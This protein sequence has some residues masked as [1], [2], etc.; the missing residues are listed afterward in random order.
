MTRAA[1][2]VILRIS[3]ICLAWRT[4]KAL[5]RNSRQQNKQSTIS[6]THHHIEIDWE[7]LQL[8]ALYAFHVIY[9]YSSLEWIVSFLPLYHYFKMIFLIVTFLIPNT[10]FANFWFEL[11]LVPMMQRIHDLLN[12]DWRDFI[13]AEAVL[14]PWQILDLFILPG[15]ISDEEAK[16]MMKL[17]QRQLEKALNS[18]YSFSVVETQEHREEDAVDSSK[19]YVDSGV[20][21]D[22]DGDS[23]VDNNDGNS[24]NER[25]L[26]TA[27]T[28][29]SACVSPSDKSIT[30]PKSPRRTRL[31]HSIEPSLQSSSL[32]SPIARSR[33][34]ASSLHLR[35]FSQDYHISKTSSRPTPESLHRRPKSNAAVSSPFMP[36][37]DSTGCKTR[38][39]LAK[40]Q[41]IRSSL[42]PRKK[43]ILH[44]PPSVAFKQTKASLL[45]QTSKSPLKHSNR[46]NPETGFQRDKNSLH[47]DDD[48]TIS[49]SSRRS[50]GNSMRKF[51]TG[52]DNIRIRDFLFD[53]ELPS[54]PS[55]KRINDADDMSVR[56]VKS[57]FYQHSRPRRSVR[58]RI[59]EEKR[60]SLEEWRKERDSLKT[61][62]GQ[63]ERSSS[64]NTSSS[65]Q[66]RTSARNTAASISS[67]KS[68]E[69]FAGQN[70]ERKTGLSHSHPSVQQ[71]MSRRSARLATKKEISE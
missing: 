36:N 64:R 39:P 46:P 2:D 9:V 8:W 60:K 20:D 23:D 53:L 22:F 69:S 66:S 62:K 45:S 70:D 16:V 24:P 10:K 11:A 21:P 27:T 33:V 44:R 41:S 42:S 5:K 25:M 48:D 59:N 68:S 7:I 55:P 50:V 61:K 57:E 13:Q 29:L 26:N 65:R 43:N 40:S 17:R 47:F 4:V 54:I 52:D 6:D 58:S 38:I 31:L 71:S 15:L 19:N 12:F 3:I 18:T 37:N 51:I 63:Q 67:V 56:S 28:L 49:L 1:C 35:K 14:L 32:T 34:A 30:S